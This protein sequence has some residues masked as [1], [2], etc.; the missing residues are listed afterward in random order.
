MAAPSQYIRVDSALAANGKVLEISDELYLEAVGIY[1]LMLGHCDLT[2]TDG[3]LTRK[4]VTGARGIAPGRD[5]LLDELKRVGLIKI[6]G[7]NITIPDYLE[8]Q[9]SADEKISAS[10]RA[11]RAARAKHCKT[12]AET[13]AETHPETHAETDAELA[14]KQ[15]ELVEQGEQA[16]TRA[17]ETP[18]NAARFIAITKVWERVAGAVPSEATKRTLRAWAEMGYSD[19]AIASALK[20]AREAKAR[21]PAAYATAILRSGDDG[22]AVTFDGVRVS[23]LA[24]YDGIA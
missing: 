18:Q 10:E 11:R 24:R 4:A 8:W 13:H 15:R 1:V 12:H 19:T 22:E 17:D 2:N 16:S 23:D 6:R 9:R 20:R 21:S 14:S 5:D 7:A 3:T